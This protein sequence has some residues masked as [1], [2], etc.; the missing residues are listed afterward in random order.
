M[1]AIIH[2]PSTALGLL[3]LIPG[4]R[5]IYCHYQHFPNDSVMSSWPSFDGFYVLAKL[6][7]KVFFRAL[8]QPPQPCLSTSCIPSIPSQQSPVNIFHTS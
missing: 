8:T 5:Y 3:I 2:I 7:S 1:F 4:I 6:K